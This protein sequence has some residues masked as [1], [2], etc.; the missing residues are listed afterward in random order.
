MSTGPP[1]DDDLVSQF[2][3]DQL[4]HAYQESSSN[5]A[6][7]GYQRAQVYLPRRSRRR[8]TVIIVAVVLLA[9]VLATLI[10]RGII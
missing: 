4:L 9:V 1:D 6:P 8:T 10:A 2:R 3:D 5:S 7:T